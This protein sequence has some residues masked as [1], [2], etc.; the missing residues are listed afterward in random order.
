MKASWLNETAIRHDHRGCVEN[1][2][3]LMPL[4]LSI[5][6]VSFNTH[7]M[8]LACLRSIYSQTAADSF[9]LIIVDNA[10]TDGS[11]QSIAPSFSQAH[12]LPLEHNV[13]FAAANNLAAKVGRGDWLLLLNPDTL[14]FNRGIERLMSFAEAHPEASIF[15]GRTVFTNGALNP[16][17]CWRRATPWSALCIAM[18]LTSLFPR[19]NLFARESYGSWKRDTVREVDIVSGC[20]FLIRRKVWDELGGFDPAFFMYGEEADLCLRARKLGHK[21]LLCPDA[22]IVHYGGA[23]EKTRADKMVKLF[24]AKAMLCQRHWRPATRWFGR[25]CLDLWAFTRTLVFGLW[26]IFQPRR[27]ES[28]RTWRDIWRRRA[29]WHKARLARDASPNPKPLPSAECLR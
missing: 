20:F 3:L 17:S 14:V 9:E 2:L 10:S 15:G 29:E 16:A 5:L 6:V 18:G 7:D 25:F 26:A 27:I 12:L 23:S 28:F 19:S 22:T 4:P 21:C 24:K 1:G 13:G 11:P 8:T